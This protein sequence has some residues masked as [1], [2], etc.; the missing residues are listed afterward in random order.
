MVP[1]RSTEHTRRAIIV[2][3]LSRQKSE[4]VQKGKD[5]GDLG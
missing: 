4:N 3:P 5:R 1:E 2:S